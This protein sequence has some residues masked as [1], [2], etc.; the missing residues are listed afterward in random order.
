MLGLH[1]SNSD[2]ALPPYS[3]SPLKDLDQPF[4]F[5]IRMRGRQ[6]RFCFYDTA[7]PTNYTLLRP[8]FIILC[9][10]ISKRSTLASLSGQW[11]KQVDDQFNLDEAIPVMVL[12]LKRDLRKEWQRDEKNVLLGESVMPLEGLGEAQKMRVDKYA[13][14]SALT[15]DLFREVLEDIAQTAVRTTLDGGGKTEWSCQIM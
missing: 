5:D 6:F 11:K 15:G 2:D 4:N 12:G 10:D 13:E 9:F 8:N 1:S 3:L 7:S 14:C